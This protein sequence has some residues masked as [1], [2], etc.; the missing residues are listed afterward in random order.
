MTPP[1]EIDIVEEFA[2]PNILIGRNWVGLALIPQPSRAPGRGGIQKRC[3][4]FP[5]FGAY[6]TVGPAA[7]TVT[8]AERPLP[9]EPTTVT[10]TRRDK[11]IGA[12]AG[13][14]FLDPSECLVTAIAPFARTLIGGDLHTLPVARGPGAVE[15]AT[16]ASRRREQDLLRGGRGR[17]HRRDRRPKLVADP[18]CLVDD[19]HRR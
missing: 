13:A 7:A 15:L 1:G 14:H 6:C 19:Q 4:V 8:L 2:E 16:G 5:A 3:N 9:S 12:G 10:T 11:A 18:A 17:E